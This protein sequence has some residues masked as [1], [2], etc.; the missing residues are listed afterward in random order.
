MQV[1]GGVH[2]GEALA[3]DCRVA[4]H[5]DMGTVVLF[6]TLIGEVFVPRSPGSGKHAYGH[7]ARRQAEPANGVVSIK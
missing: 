2:V 1:G 6:P 5:S 7:P 3:G 4:I